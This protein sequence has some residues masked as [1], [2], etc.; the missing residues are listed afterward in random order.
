MGRDGAIETIT[1]ISLTFVPKIGLSLG[2]P[3]YSS[4]I[5]QSNFISPVLSPNVHTHAQ[6]GRAKVVKRT[7]CFLTPPLLSVYIFI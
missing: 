2:T 3:Q 6:L 5:L 4:S 1:Q 7:R